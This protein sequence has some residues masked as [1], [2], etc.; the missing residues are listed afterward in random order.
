MNVVAESEIT[1]VGGKYELLIVSAV[2][3]KEMT[4]T[5]STNCCSH[6]MGISMFWFPFEEPFGLAVHLTW[7][8]VGETPR[9]NLV[10]F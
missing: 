2:P 7:S 5:S 9:I 8:T 4:F 1:H 6:L 10:F 3:F